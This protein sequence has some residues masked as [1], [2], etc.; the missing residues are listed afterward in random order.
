MDIKHQA[1][2]VIEQVFCFLNSVNNAQY[3]QSLPIFNG[4]TLGQHI[5]HIY[6]FYKCLLDGVEHGIINYDNR[7]RDFLIETDCQNAQ[8]VFKEIASKIDHLEPNLE[9]QIISNKTLEQQSEGL[10]SS[11]GRELLYAVDH[12]IHHLAIVKIG[13]KTAFPE[14]ELDKNMGVAPSTIEYQK[15]CVQ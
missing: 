4:S 14:I 15:T 6:C 12:A 9:V 8:F 3:R 10:R 7:V 5:R 11:F 1:K 13:V 2:E